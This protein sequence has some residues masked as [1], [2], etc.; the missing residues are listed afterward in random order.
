MRPIGDVGLVL[1]QGRDD[2]AEGEEGLVDQPGLLLPLPLP[3]TTGRDVIM[4]YISRC[5]SVEG[6]VD[7]PA[8]SAP[9]LHGGGGDAAACLGVQ[10]A[11]PPGRTLGRHPMAG[12]LLAS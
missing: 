5:V 12:T 1:D 11:L 6:P 9:P 7:Q 4:P 10:C 3:T 2:A 8:P